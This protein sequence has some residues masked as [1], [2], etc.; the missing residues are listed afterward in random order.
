MA[1]LEIAWLGVAGALR[2][3]VGVSPQALARSTNAA[4]S[5]TTSRAR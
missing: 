4:V 1:P 5:G 3:A 2:G